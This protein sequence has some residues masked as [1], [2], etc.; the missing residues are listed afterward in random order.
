MKYHFNLEEAGYLLLLV[1]RDRRRLEKDLNFPDLE[2]IEEKL[3]NGRAKAIES[4]KKSNGYKELKCTL[5]KK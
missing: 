3:Q 1:R 2:L 4:F 5:K